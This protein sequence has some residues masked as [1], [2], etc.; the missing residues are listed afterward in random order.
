MCIIDSQDMNITLRASLETLWGKERNSVW[1]VFQFDN[2]VYFNHEK[3]LLA[4]FK[5]SMYELIGNRVQASTFR[6]HQRIVVNDTSRPML[7]VAI[8]TLLKIKKNNNNVNGL[9]LMHYIHITVVFN[10]AYKTCYCINRKRH[11]FCT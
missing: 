2:L 7:L 8:L 5:I 4:L 11:Y 1:V 3:K 10:N 6:Y 9:P